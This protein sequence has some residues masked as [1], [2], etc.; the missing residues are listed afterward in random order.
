MQPG[1]GS[2]LPANRRKRKKMKKHGF[3]IHLYSGPD[4]GFTLGRAWQQ[5]GGREADLLEVDL[6]RGQD[7][8]MLK[9][10][11]V[12]GALLAAVLTGQAKGLVGGP[13]CRTRS[14][15]GVE[16]PRPIRRWDGEEFG[17]QDA[18]EEEK[19]KLWEDDVLMWRMIFLG[20]VGTYL[21]QARKEPDPFIF[22]LEQPASPKEYKPEVV[23]LWDTTQWASLK[24]RTWME[25]NNLLPATTWRSSHKAHYLR[26]KPGTAP[27]G[28]CIEVF[29]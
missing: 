2:Q 7:H 1:E 20:I 24:E 27:R 11:G 9:P 19:K 8:D 10:G 18:T 21:R 4:E 12:Y 23:S 17:I 22:S 14:V 6:N 29:G 26:G 15:P 13:N 25:G 28:L 16:P 5:I 3:V